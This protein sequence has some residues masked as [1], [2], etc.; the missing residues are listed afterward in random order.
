M[1]S[2]ITFLTHHMKIQTERKRKELKYKP[3]I[4]WVLS[5]NGSR[6]DITCARP[7]D[8]KCTRQLKK[9]P[10][11]TFLGDLTQ[12]SA[13]KIHKHAKP[14]PKEQRNHHFQTV[15]HLLGGDHASTKKWDQEEMSCTLNAPRP[16][17]LSQPKWAH[18]PQIPQF[19]Q[20][21]AALLFT[22]KLNC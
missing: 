16:C 21:P 12:K 20:S 6:P 13:S 7:F 11:G 17:R 4:R 22:I 10:R 5:W 1:A 14:M 18:S 15:P 2:T 19:T 3:L 8:G 9:S